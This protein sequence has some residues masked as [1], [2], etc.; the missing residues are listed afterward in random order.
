M[1]LQTK[2]LPFKTKETRTHSLYPFP[3]PHKK[4]KENKEFD[5]QCLTSKSREPTLVPSVNDDGLETWIQT[6]VLGHVTP[7]K[8]L[9]DVIIAIKHKE[10]KKVL[11]QDIFQVPYWEAWVGG[12]Q[13]SQEPSDVI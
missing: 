7:R 11:I 5:F 3:P 9:H 4:K 2:T 1:I 10:Q 12:L 6:A 8:W 13:R